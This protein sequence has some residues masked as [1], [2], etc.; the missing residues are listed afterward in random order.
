MSPWLP[1]FWMCYS[2]PSAR[3]ATTCCHQ[4]SFCTS[5]P[6]ISLASVFHQTN[7][8]FAPFPGIERRHGEG[9]A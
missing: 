6:N 4:H 9:R 7:S 5:A 8:F 1:D 2:H 3:A